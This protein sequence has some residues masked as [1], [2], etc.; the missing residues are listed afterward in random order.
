MA[1]ALTICNRPGCPTKIPQG[2]GRCAECRADADRARRPRG[3]PYAT[4]GHLLFRDAVLAR[5]PI[6]VLCDIRIATVADHYP[7]ERVDLVRAGLDPNDPERGR[8]LCAGCHN[9]YTAATSPGG[10]NRRD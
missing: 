8:G 3:N 10:W 1:R 5:D 7:D 6:C 2:Q 9:E 4:R